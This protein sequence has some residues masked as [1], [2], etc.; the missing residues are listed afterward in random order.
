MLHQWLR[1]FHHQQQ[2]LPPLP[3]VAP[4]FQVA[5]STASVSDPRD[6]TASVSDTR[7]GT[8]TVLA[9]ATSAPSVS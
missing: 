4:V 5:R 2:P 3:F 7:D 6:G 8:A 9:A 1:Q